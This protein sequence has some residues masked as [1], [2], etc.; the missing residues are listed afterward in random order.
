VIGAVVAEFAAG[1]GQAQG[2]AWRILEA[3][4]RL[5]TARMIAALVVLGV[6]AAILHGLLE[7]AEKAGL[8]WWRG[9]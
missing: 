6:M 1:S 2:L 3:G 7:V 5:Q 4:N 9:R 8:R